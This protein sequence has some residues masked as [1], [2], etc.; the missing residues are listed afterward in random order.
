MK[1]SLLLK[2]CGLLLLIT[3]SFYFFM[4]WKF[5][6]NIDQAIANS[7]DSIDISYDS[8]KLSLG[9]NALIEGGRL[10]VPAL[11]IQ[12]TFDEVEYGVGSLFE[13][14]FPKATD[15]N[16]ALPDH[17]YL[18]LTNFNLPL[19]TSLVSM[20]KQTEQPDNLSA[21]QASGCGQKMQL[22]I[23]EYL[24]MG[25]SN[26]NLSGSF[27]LNKESV[28]GDVI[29][30]LSG[31]SAFDVENMTRFSSSFELSNIVS[32]LTQYSDLALVPTIDS[33]SMDI[34][35]LG[36]NQ[37]KNAYCA[38]QEG[39]SI[40]E[41]IDNHILLVGDALKTAKLNMTDDIKRTYRELLQPGSTVHLSMEPPL[42]YSFDNISHYNEKDLR[43]AL[44]LKIQVNNFDLPRI[45]D[46]WQLKKFD[47]VVVLTPKQIEKKNQ[48][49]VFKYY[50]K[51]LVNAKRYIN[52]KVKVI[53]TDN[54]T[55]EGVLKS[56]DKK[57][58]RVSVLR[59]RGSSEGAI[60]KKRIK[61]FYAYL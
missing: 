61:S 5:K 42:G 30:K 9:G 25:Y 19:T 36:Y 16:F 28:V 52:K 2:V 47:K 53:T 59:D 18:K 55:F 41:Y 12:M 14:L 46:G 60:S 6:A 7:G 3:F 29:S 48:V 39:V 31:E 50:A 32:D 38:A 57:S 10:Y 35:D 21:L 51:P 58:L 37:R 20:I 8:A 54:V 22:G 56:V 33:V 17:L 15:D 34:T 44:G 13:L 1:S 49:K 11:N 43:E 24:A 26:I 23:D 27:S 45:F 40:D 4:Q